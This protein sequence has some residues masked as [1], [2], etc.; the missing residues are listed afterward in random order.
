MQRIVALRSEI[1]VYENQ[2]LHPA[3]LARQDDPV[4]AEA[5]LFG[6]LRRFQRG[7][8]HRAAHHHVGVFRARQTRVVVHH[9]RRQ[10]LVEA[11]PVD[12]DAHRPVVAACRF[13]QG[14]ELFV[15]LVAASDVARIDAQF[16]QRLRAFR[17]LGQELVAVEVEVADQRHAAAQHVEPLTDARH[18]GGGLQGVDGEPHQFRAGLGERLH[19]A[20]GGRDI[21]RV[22]VGHR[23][24]HHGRIPSY[25]YGTNLYLTGETTDNLRHH[26]SS[27]AILQA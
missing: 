20:H 19:L 3:H 2:I 4:T 11:A 8:H 24:H 15:A 26:S 14:G 18:R 22:G 13:D 9:A 6:L 21:D 7:R 23:L 10:R 27:V 12:A 5:Q 1:A 17:H 16:R 25:Q